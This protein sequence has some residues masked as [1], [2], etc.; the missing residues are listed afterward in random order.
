MKN[1]KQKNKIS[2]ACEAVNTLIG[3]ILL[4]GIAIALFSVLYV[5]LSGMF[6]S[7][8]SPSVNLFAHVDG[9]NIIIE[10]L[11][12]ESLLSDTS[13]I[14]TL[15]NENKEITFNSSFDKNGNNL[16]DLGERVSFYNSSI[17]DNIQI[18][19][20]VID[21]DSNTAL[22]LGTLQ[23]G[24]TSLLQSTPSDNGY[25]EI[26]SV[27][28][29]S[30]RSDSY[31]FSHTV[32]GS[33]RLLTVSFSLHEVS[34]T[35]SSVSYA[36]QSLTKLQH[37][38]RGSDIRA[39]VWYLVNPPTGTNNVSINLVLEN[40][41]SVGA[42]SYINVNQSR[43]IS[44]NNVKTGSG[45]SQAVTMTI[46]S[47][48][49]DMIQDVIASR[50]VL[51]LSVGANQTQR[52]NRVIGEQTYLGGGSTQPGAPTSVTINWKNNV[53]SKWAMIGFNINQV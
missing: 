1:Q 17:D 22:F 30:F 9:Q 6:V 3:T 47:N 23:Q 18:E 44:R 37:K 35:V 32:S 4:L 25:T 21:T 36:G 29:I 43:P 49:G 5:S 13:L 11:G 41:V 8:D 7:N 2:K 16:W 42:I 39:E 20:S 31:N 12:G 15:G 34:R 28:S 40:N 19:L 46:P 14:I 45:S 52:W 38:N 48:T 33:N 50:E 27:T 26:D 10:H 24:N 51:N 53:S